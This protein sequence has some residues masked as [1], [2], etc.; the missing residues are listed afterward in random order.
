MTVGTIVRMPDRTLWRVDFVNACRARLIP[1]AK[2]HVILA[3]G[4]E[5][6]ASRGAINISPDSPLE[7]ITDVERAKDEQ[8]LAEA[9]REERELKVALR[10]A[11]APVVKHTTTVMVTKVKAPSIGDS[12]R[13]MKWQLGPVLAPAFK[14]GTLAEQ[15]FSYITSHPG[16]TT[17]EIVEGVLSDAAVA[18]CVSRFNQ[19][20]YIH[21]A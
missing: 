17:A 20:G 18:A 11:N 6:D 16:Q 14:K 9:E 13:Y 12:R 21:K 5:F 15:V 1:L 8:A 4:S 2:R 19:A 3:D 7:V 10:Q